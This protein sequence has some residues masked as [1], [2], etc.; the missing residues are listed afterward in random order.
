MQDDLKAENTNIK[1]IESIL[2]KLNIYPDEISV[3]TI[4]DL[5]KSTKST[6]T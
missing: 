5:L 1:E 2:N 3:P 6:N 4:K